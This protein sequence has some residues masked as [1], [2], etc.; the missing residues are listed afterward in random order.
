VSST[1]LTAQVAATELVAAGNETI[2]VTNPGPGGGTSGALP[3]VVTP[4]LAPGEIVVNVTANDLV[5]DPVNHVIYLSLFETDPTKNDVQ[6]M[7]PTTGALGASA[8]AGS[9]ANQLSI[10]KSSKYLYV[11]LAGAP[12]VQRLSL[13]RLDQAVP[14]SLGYDTM[15][16]PYYAMDLH[17]GPVSDDTISVVR[18]SPGVTP[19][20]QGGMVIYDDGIPR[21]NTLCGIT[22]GFNENDPGCSTSVMT[23]PGGNYDSTQWNSDGS[24]MF[25]VDNQDTDYAFYT[26]PVS[27]S[28]FG[29]IATYS[30]IAYG[31]LGSPGAIHFEASTN[32]VY[33]DSGYVIEPGAG[34][35]VGTF[36]ASGLMVPDGS[37]GVAFFLGQLA[38]DEGTS[39]YTLESFDLRTFAPIA[40]LTISNVTAN[41]THLIR[42]GANG[43]AF[44]T[45]S[46]NQGSP[47]SM[48][49]ISGSF[50]DGS[51]SMTGPPPSQNVQ[52]TW[53]IPDLTSSAPPPFQVTH[54]F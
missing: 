20:E 27:S 10:S 25:A 47:A 38:S 51:K 45:Y 2:S 41:P 39:T 17:A 13:P 12:N 5:W 8:F 46:R 14:I 42:W 31:K 33:D 21:P 7:D 28:G 30:G 3:F 22:G 4:P 19:S 24:E 53:K 43:L 32:Y 52:R 34:K 40:T 6:I 48:Y 44:T 11:G 37:L 23:G 35:I 49:L 16:G 36:N 50:V 26:V 18:E 29:S 1:T 54:S 9:G 15:Y